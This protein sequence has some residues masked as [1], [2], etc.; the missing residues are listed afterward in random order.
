MYLYELD[1][2]PINF[3]LERLSTLHFNPLLTGYDENLALYNDLDPDSYFCFD[4]FNCEYFTESNF[5]EA[6]ENA[7]TS[8]NL[9][10]LTFLHLNIRSLNRNFDDLEILLSN[11]VNK[12]TVIGVSETWL[13]TS[14][15]NCDMEGYNLCTT[16]VNIKAVG[17]SVCI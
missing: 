6:L 11:I 14:E 9:N 2:G 10:C 4:K 15:H 1:N 5:N 3:D 7:K 12:F 16:I 17:V 13:Q 8:A